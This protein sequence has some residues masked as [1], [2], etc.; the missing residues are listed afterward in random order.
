MTHSYTENE[1]YHGFRLTEQRFIREVNA[2]CLYFEHVK[3][4]ARLFRI[5]ADDPNKTF[6]IG[7]K[8]LPDSDNGAPHIME[9]SVLNGSM[10]FPVKSPF[11][12][13][14]K[15]SLSTFL[16]AF[17]SKDYTMY[18]VASLNEKDYF[19][20]IHVYL[21][22]VFKPLI[23]TDP[24]ILK[25]E[26]WHY[27]LTDPAAPVVYTGVVYNE[28]KGALSNPQRELWYHVFR[29][30]FPD[31][32]YGFESGGHPDA[33]PSLTYGQ[34][35]NFHRKYY[36]PDNSYIFLY[37]NA[38][39]DR[40][41]DFI[42]RMYL[43]GYS[44]SEKEITIQDQ[45][46]FGAMKDITEYYPA[47]E[48][49]DVANQAFLTYNFIAGQNSDLALTMALD[50]LCEVLVNQESAPIRLALQQA[51]IG[52]DVSAS[53]SNFKQHSVQIAA[54][55]ANGSDKQRFFEVV[56]RTL[57]EVVKNG[58]DKDEIRGVINRMEFRLREGD[59]AQKGLNYMNQS[60]ARWFFCDDPFSGLEYEKILTEV[61][62]SLTE[63]YLESIVE[64]YFLDPANLVLLSLEPAPGL[65]KVNDR[66]NEE[67]LAGYKNAL[68]P[69]E[70]D[71]LISETGE[72][73]AFQQREDTPE[74]LA[75]IPVLELGDIDP[76][77]IPIETVEHNIGG[78]PV[79]GF[80]HFTNGVVYINLCFD[81]QVIPQELIPYASLLANLLG[82]LS[83]EDHS[84]GELNKLLNIHTGGFFTSLRGYTAQSLDD[85][86]LPKFMVSSKAMS[87][88]T[89]MLIGLTAEILNRTTYHDAGRLKNLISRHQSQLD[90]QMKGNGFQVANRRLTSYFSKQGMFSELTG[91][92][93]YYRFV[94]GLL[95]DID[96]RIDQIAD[97]LQQVARLIFTRGNLVTGLTCSGE[98]RIAISGQLNQL[99]ERLPGG[100]NEAAPWLF[101]TKPGNEGLMSASNVQY[102]TLG[103]N[104]QKLGYQWNGRMRVLNQVL[105]T[106]WLQTQVRVIGGAYGGFSS[107]TPSG[108]ITLN[109]YRD[110]NLGATL[111]TFRK[112]PAYLRQFDADPQTMTRYII[113]TIADMDAPLTP[114]QQGLKA[115]NMYLSGRT[116]QERQADRDAVLST[117]PQHIRDF[118]KL[119]DDVVQ[120]QALCIYGNGDKLNREKELFGELVQV[121]L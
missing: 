5:M 86:L 45:A 109:S 71:R 40:E 92:I 13:L 104:F 65:D 94:T 1:I 66:R 29:H 3:S 82:S 51:G 67:I 30:L 90:A 93:S 7:F 83:T 99:F 33:I 43:S 18:P 38:D 108:N 103:Y 105:S 50:I 58:I 80:D 107:I 9:H 56:T 41:L 22:A 75:S 34:F 32:P 46:P 114:S 10:S 91:G 26:G 6:C 28:M 113:G 70:I 24:R 64:K 112:T 69:D 35:L 68:G 89:G 120:Q 31:N 87:G 27:E 78:V 98:D 119:L 121:L 63:N 76:G 77:V 42:D 11:D 106:D 102:V 117:T 52:Q 57:H 47:L 2:S 36:H 95:N 4:G 101:E 110:P 116:N 17:T 19:N 39:P 23:Y 111:E 49:T 59:D 8:T 81:L 15:G 53:S 16:N 54:I 100:K 88:K 115:L 55:N 73:I 60:L 37:G 74:A 48:G 85:L 20:L 21:D 97:R 14:L 72:L 62:R 79:A 96:Q 25:Q 12:V 44:R 118:S 84:Y 61:K